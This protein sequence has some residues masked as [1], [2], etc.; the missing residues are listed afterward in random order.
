MS[1]EESRRLALAEWHA[2]EAIACAAVDSPHEDSHLASAIEFLR[3]A[4][5]WRPGVETADDVIAAICNVT[6]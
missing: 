6:R 5:A 3:S 4:K 2:R 1:P